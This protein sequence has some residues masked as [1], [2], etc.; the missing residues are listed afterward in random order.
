MAVCDLDAASHNC[1]APSSDAAASMS[2]SGE[3]TTEVTLPADT[4]RVAASDRVT[5]S[6]SNTVPSSETVA[7][8]P[9][10]GENDTE[11]TRPE[12]GKSARVRAVAPSY[13]HTPM[14][15]A[16]ASVRPSDERATARFPDP[17]AP[18][19]RRAVAPSGRCHVGGASSNTPTPAPDTER[20]QNTAT[21][22]SIDTTDLLLKI[23]LLMLNSLPA[24]IVEY[25]ATW[26]DRFGKFT[27]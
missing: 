20:P 26:M 18:F 7:S 5:T 3:N 22:T 10:S 11:L 24:A 4:S 21:T 27:T 25:T 14:P 15:L 19:P 12:L 23:F 8:V 17:I 2:P 6:H 16:T 9:P 13:S 1:T